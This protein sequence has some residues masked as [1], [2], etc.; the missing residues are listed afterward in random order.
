MKFKNSND[1][2]S[3]T[4]KYNLI[5]YLIDKYKYTSIYLIH[6]VI[7]WFLKI[8]ITKLSGKLYRTFI[9]GLER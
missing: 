6:S 4:F 1:C 9:N 3:V 8:I 2:E 7:L 5:F